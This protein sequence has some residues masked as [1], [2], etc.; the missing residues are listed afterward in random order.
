MSG[1]RYT[2]DEARELLKK[3]KCLEYGHDYDVAHLSSVAGH[4]F[5]QSVTCYNCGRTWSVGE[6][7][8][9]VSLGEIV[10]GEETWDL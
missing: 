4:S 1:E 10:N 8:G 9:G 7:T 3:R 6:G 5:P 2:L